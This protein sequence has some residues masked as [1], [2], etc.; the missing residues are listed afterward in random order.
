MQARRW[1]SCASLVERRPIC[2]TSFL[3]LAPVG[4]NFD[5]RPADS[6]AIFRSAAPRRQR[7]SSRVNQ[8][9]ICAVSL[10]RPDRRTTL[11]LSGTV[12]AASFV[13]RRRLQ[14]LA[15]AVA[16]HQDHALGIL[17]DEFVFAIEHL[18]SFRP[19]LQV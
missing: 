7:L 17:L 15:G 9:S 12:V 4:A 16:S 18:D 2:F 19:P 1:T 10:T 6:R 11:P 3:K 13:D 14:L 8:S 5:F